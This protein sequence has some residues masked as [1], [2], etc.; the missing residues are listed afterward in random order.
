MCLW[1]KR[2]IQ[3]TGRMSGF[4]K[5]ECPL[6]C[7]WKLYPCLHFSPATQVGSAH[8]RQS[9]RVWWLNIP[10]LKFALTVQGARNHA[11]MRLFSYCISLTLPIS[12]K[13]QFPALLFLSL[14]EQNQPYIG[15]HW[16]IEYSLIRE[17]CIRNALDCIWEQTFRRADTQL[18][19]RHFTICIQLTLK[20]VQPQIHFRSWVWSL[21]ELPEWSSWILREWGILLWNEAGLSLYPVFWISEWVLHVWQTLPKLVFPFWHL[22]A[23]MK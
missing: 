15:L 5:S 3:S 22:V 2:T 11:Q 12:K 13:T 10:L 4:V 9:F 17:S 7:N 1:Q 18:L 20:E 6:C 14:S 21:M 16:T 19:S 23:C 8:S